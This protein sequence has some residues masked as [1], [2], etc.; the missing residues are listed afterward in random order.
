MTPRVQEPSDVLVPEELRHPSGGSRRVSP[1]YL[2]HSSQDISLRDHS[3]VT[4]VGTV[5]P[6]IAHHE[7][8]PIRHDL[9][10][11]IIVAPNVGGYVV[12]LQ[13][14]II[15]KHPAVNDSHRILFGGDD[16]LHEHLVR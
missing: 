2:N 8:V 1:G 4:A 5:V 14:S 3:P 15:Y 6:M 7:V 16:A 9:W 12:L 10:S 11:P 13:R